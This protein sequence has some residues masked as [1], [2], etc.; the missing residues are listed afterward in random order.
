MGQVY[1]TGYEG[2]RGRD[3]VTAFGLADGTQRWRAEME[4]EQTTELSVVGDYLLYEGSSRKYGQGVVAFTAADGTPR[5]SAATDRVW[6]SWPVV[7]GGYLYFCEHSV[8][9]DETVLAAY[10]VGGREC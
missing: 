9:H 7:G 3:V 2:F 8:R 5:W 4:Q 6:H 10:S 1:V